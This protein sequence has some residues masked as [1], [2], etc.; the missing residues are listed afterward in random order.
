MHSICNKIIFETS[1]HVF[2]DK[3]IDNMTCLG[4]SQCIHFFYMRCSLTK[5]NELWRCHPLNEITITDPWPYDKVCSL[6]IT[7]LFQ[8]QYF[9]SFVS[10]VRPCIDSSL[11][12]LSPCC[13]FESDCVALNSSSQTLLDYVPT[14]PKQSCLY[15]AN[16]THILDVVK[17]VYLCHDIFLKCNL[18]KSM[19]SFQRLATVLVSGRKDFSLSKKMEEKPY[20]LK[21]P[22][23]TDVGC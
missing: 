11:W 5:N 19:R 20:E 23:H 2:H 21:S 1:V 6:V 8:N 12:S 17:P 9:V 14:R 3:N 4:Y 22:L 7:I 16:I 18:N 13:D 10:V 15:K